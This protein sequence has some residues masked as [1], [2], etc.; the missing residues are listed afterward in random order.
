MLRAW[1]ARDSLPVGS[2]CDPSVLRVQSCILAACGAQ[3]LA[4]AAQSGQHRGTGKIQLPR[5]LGGR[6]AQ[7]HLQHERLPIFI[8]QFQHRS[9]HV[10]DV[11]LLG[12]GQQRLLFGDQLFHIHRR[13]A[14]DVLDA[15][16]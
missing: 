10:A 11:L 14:L 12:G 8:R 6:I 16:S 15:A 13:E 9:A 4:R 5:D 2:A 1:K 3:L 7:Q